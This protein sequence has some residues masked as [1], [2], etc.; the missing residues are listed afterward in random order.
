METKQKH[1]GGRRIT[2]TGD[3]A[4]DN[5][6]LRLMR[7]GLT[8]TEL[9]ERLGVHKSDISHALS[10]RAKHKRYM[11]LRKR[12]RSALKVLKKR[13][14]HPEQIYDQLGYRNRYSYAWM[15]ITRLIDFAIR[16]MRPIPPISLK[17]CADSF[18]WNPSTFYKAL[19]NYPHIAAWRKERARQILDRYLRELYEDYI[20]Y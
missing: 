9:A 17:G 18:L 13:K 14:L 8:M 11:K 16:A 4:S 20:L 12:I 15:Q 1:R 10:P 2:L 3:R 6:R 19:H 7:L 5:L